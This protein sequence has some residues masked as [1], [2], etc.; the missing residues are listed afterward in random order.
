MMLTMQL[1]L[2][3]GATVTVMINQNAES[4]VGKKRTSKR[5]F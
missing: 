3:M 1:M 5:G 2:I 4:E